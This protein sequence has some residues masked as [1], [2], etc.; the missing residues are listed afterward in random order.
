[1][2]NSAFFS[3]H[4]LFRAVIY[5]QF[6]RIICILRILCIMPYVLHCPGVI[7]VGPQ[8][9]KAWLGLSLWRSW[10]TS[11]WSKELWWNW[12]S[13]P[14]ET[15]ILTLSGWKTATSSPRRNTHISGT[16]ICISQQKQ[17]YR[18]QSNFLSHNCWTMIK[19]ICNMMLFTALGR[20]QRLIVFGPSHVSKVVCS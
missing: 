1:M 16:Y 5:S 6:F 10:R 7:F 14:L 3:Y 15:R 18:F 17:L 8:L 9:G 13:G 11:R 19:E 12:L 4:Q 20:N 2:I